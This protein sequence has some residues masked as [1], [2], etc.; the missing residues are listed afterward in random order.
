MWL[1]GTCAP[2]QTVNAAIARDNPGRFGLLFVV[3][4]VEMIG[5]ENLEIKR[6]VLDLI[7]P[8]ILRGRRSGHAETHQQEPDDRG[9]NGQSFHRCA[10][11]HARL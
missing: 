11:G 7:P 8:E 10:L 1:C 2:V 6:A 5:L 4:E 3:I 9:A